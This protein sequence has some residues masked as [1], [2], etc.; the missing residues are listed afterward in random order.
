MFLINKEIQELQKTLI[1][2]NLISGYCHEA[3]SAHLR[4]V[5]TV[6][7]TCKESKKAKKCGNIDVNVKSGNSMKSNL[8]FG[9]KHDGLADES[10]GD[11]ERDLQNTPTAETFSTNAYVSPRK[12]LKNSQDDFKASLSHFQLSSSEC[13]EK[14]ED[15][16]DG[17]PQKT[18]TK[19]PSRIAKTDLKN[20]SS[21][22]THFTLHRK[23][24][25]TH[26]RRQKVALCMLPVLRNPLRE[27]GMAIQL[28]D[29]DSKTFS[30]Y[31]QNKDSVNNGRS[32]K[33]KAAIKHSL[34]LLI[35]EHN[36]SQ[37]SETV[38]NNKQR[39][40]H[41]K[42]SNFVSELSEFRCDV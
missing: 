20:S 16:S 22:P 38:N 12:D 35:K 39:D 8:M 23:E 9:Q 17:C 24:K 6:F 7:S 1:D 21:P 28:Q 30:R 14:D 18:S 31:L 2:I 5:S 41:E 32:H 4:S 25:Q 26:Q 11:G 3:Y 36:C 13:N 29:Q 10:S 37:I 42:V 34:E 40:L 15:E 19:S 27:Q 33:S